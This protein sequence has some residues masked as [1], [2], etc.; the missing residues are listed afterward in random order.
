MPE[1]VKNSKNQSLHN[2][3]HLRLFR[4]TGMS[5]Q[6]THKSILELREAIHDFQGSCNDTPVVL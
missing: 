2:V 6:E 4:T 3:V 5:F 1:S